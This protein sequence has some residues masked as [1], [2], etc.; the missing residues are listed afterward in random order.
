MIPLH[1]ILG[2]TAMGKT[3]RSVALASRY[4]SPVLVLDRVQCHPDLAVGSGR[5]THDELHN[6]QRF[7]LT[8]RPVH[9]GV[10]S[11][12]EAVDRLV[13]HRKM[14][15]DGGV[16]RLILEGCSISILSEL[17]TRG[18][19][20][21]DATVQV[22]CWLEASA[23]AYADRV[24][25]RVERLLGY[26]DRMARTLVDELADLWPHPLVRPRLQS[27][28]GYRE[29]IDLCAAQGLD[30]RLLRGLPARLRRAQFAGAVRD[31]H[32]TYAHHQ[33]LALATALPELA[34]RGFEVTL[35]EA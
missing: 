4:D 26:G 16:D 7:Y 24:T 14:F 5:P 2:P 15:A 8:E 34:A 1:L 12:A 30:P 6:T 19:W 25:E 18:D 23:T 17:L 28:T 21:E 9:H 13:H 22:E 27:I 10:I 35:C 31:A 3:G 11:A 29:V 32:L 20:F 33:R